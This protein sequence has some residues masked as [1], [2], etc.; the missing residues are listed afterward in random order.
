MNGIQEVVGSIPSGST[1]SASQSEKLEP[2]TILT[3]S[4]L[5]IE[6]RLVFADRG[7][8]RKAGRLN[9]ATADEDFGHRYE[10]PDLGTGLKLLRPKHEQN[11]R[12]EQEACCTG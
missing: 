9:L 5:R 2:P 7:P 8:G 11:R 4:F 3:A 10:K 1:R 6:P 12:D